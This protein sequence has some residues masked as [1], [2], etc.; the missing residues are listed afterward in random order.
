LDAKGNV[1]GIA[2]ATIALERY[3]AACRVACHPV[4]NVISG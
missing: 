1:E 2:D 4:A 3:L